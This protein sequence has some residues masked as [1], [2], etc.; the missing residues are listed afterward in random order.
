MIKRYKGYGTWE[1]EPIAGSGNKAK[2]EKYK[3]EYEC[4]N[5]ETSSYILYIVEIPD[6]TLIFDL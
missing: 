6:I 3:D 5:K 1:A 4:K 2:L